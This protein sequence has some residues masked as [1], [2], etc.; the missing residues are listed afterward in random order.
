MD[1]ERKYLVSGQDG[2]RFRKAGIGGLVLTLVIAVLPNASKAFNDPCVIDAN[3]MT[4]S[5]NQEDGLGY[6]F[7]SPDTLNVQNLTAEVRPASGRAIDFKNTG[8]TLT[9]VHLNVDSSVS[10]L[11][12]TDG[13]M[14]LWVQ[15]WRYPATGD[16]ADGGDSGAVT[17][18]SYAEEINTSGLHSVG[19]LGLS[20]GSDGAINMSVNVSAGVGG[21]GG[22]GGAVAVSGSG[23]ID[24]DGLLSR[25]IF[26][27][28]AGGNG[29]KG[30][31][32]VTPGTG[33]RG[34]AGGSVTVDGSWVIDTNGDYADGI[35]ALSLGGVGGEGGGGVLSAPGGTGGASSNGGK[36]TVTLTGGRIITRQNVSSGVLAQSIGGFG[37][38]GAADGGLFYA[39]GGEGGAGGNGG[40][41]KIDS[42]ADITTYGI[43]SHALFAESI[44]GGG[45]AGGAAGSVITA[46]GGEGSVSGHGGR[47]DVI[48]SGRLETSGMHAIGI[49]AQ[50]IGG[51]GGDAGASGSIVGV[52][53]KSGAA[54]NGGVVDVEN[55]GLILTHGLLSHGVLAQSIGGGGGAAGDTGGIVAVGGGGAGGGDGGLVD[56]ENNARITTEGLLAKGLFVQSIGGGGGD[57]GSAGGFV[58]VGGSGSST[59]NGG[60]VIVS[61]TGTITTKLDL[62]EAILAQSIGGGGGSGGSTGGIFSFGGKGNSGGDAGTVTVTNSGN[63]ETNGSDSTGVFAQ[64]VGGGGGTGGGTVAVGSP[65]S[66]S[67]GGQG[68]A[69]GAGNNVTV[70]GIG[71]TISTSGDRSD[72]IFAQSVGGSGGN[73]G[74]AVSISAG[75][76]GSM[77]IAVGGNAGGGGAGGDVTVESSSVITTDGADATGIVAQSV[78][79]SGGNGGF[80]VAVAISQTGPSMSLA[81][82]GK[83]GEAGDSGGLVTMN[84]TGGSITTLGDRSGGILAQSVGGGGGNGGFSVSASGA[85]AAGALGF[86]GEGG[87]GRLGGTVDVT[88]VSNV[89]TSGTNANGITAQ[90][91][92][93]G[94]GNGGFSVVANVAGGSGSLSFGGT[95]G[96]GNLGGRVKLDNSGDIITG[97]GQAGHGD[98]SIGILAQSV[99]GG[100]G[101]GGYSIVGSASGSV[102]VNLSF[103][104]AGGFGG[105]GGLVDFDN[106]GSVTTTGNDAHGIVAQSVGGGGG[107]GG[108]SVKGSVSGSVDAGLAI[109][110]AGGIGANG[111]YV[112]VSNTG[113]FISTSGDRAFGLL[114]Q[115][116]GGQGGAGGYSVSAGASFYGTA[117][118]AIG[119][120]GGFGGQSSRVKVFNSANVSTTGSDAHGVLAQSVGGGGGAGGFGVAA[121][122]S[123]VNNLSVGIGGKGGLGGAVAGKVDV[124]QTGDITTT[125]ERAM[126]M[127]A[128]SVGGQGGDGGMSFAGGV[129]SVGLSVAVGGEG[130]HG[131]S[132]GN[133]QVGFDGAISTATNHSHGI[134]AQS[135]GGGGG[136]GGMAIKGSVSSLGDLGVA[137]GGL[138]GVGGTSG[139]VVVWAAGGS[140]STTGDFASGIIAQSAGGSGGDGGMSLTAGATSFINLNASIGGAGGAAGQAGNVVANVDASVETQGML[141]FGVVAQS[142]GGSG[143]TGGLSIAASVTAGPPIPGLGNS[144]NVSVGGAGG[145][146]AFGENVTVKTTSTVQTSGMLAH[147]I[148]AQSIGGS[149]GGGGMSVIGAVNVGGKISA[150]ANVSVG[151]WG[152]NGA[153]AGDVTVNSYGGLVKTTGNMANGILAQSIGGSGGSSGGNYSEA[154][155]GLLGGPDLGN[156]IGFNLDVGGKG[157]A[158]AIAG[159][160]VINNFASIETDGSFAHG[161]VGQSIGG[162]GGTGAISVGISAGGGVG[163]IGVDVGGTFP[164]GEAPAGGTAGTVTI[165]NSGASVTTQ[166][167]GSYGILAQSIGGA[168][169]NASADTIWF[170]YYP[171][172]PSNAISVDVSVGGVGGAGGIA[173]DVDVTNDASIETQGLVAHGIVAQSLGGG[174]GAGGGHINGAA[175]LGNIG[176]SI[177]GA[178]GLGAVAGTVDVTNGG[179]IFTK[180]ER[181]YGVLAQS[182]GG[183]GGEGGLVLSNGVA[184]GTIKLGI[185]GDGGVGGTSNVVTVVNTAG[186]KTEGVGSHGIM[187]Q[188]L[189]GGGGAGGHV[190]QGAVSGSGSL[191]VSV[192]GSGGGSAI[193]DLVSVT[194]SGGLIETGADNAHGVMAQS[195]GGTGGDGN[196]SVAGSMSLMPAINVSIGGSGGDS[197]VAGDVLVDVSNSI[198]TIGAGSHGIMAQSIGGGGGSAGFGAAGG[199]SGTGAI[200][201]GVGGSGGSGS[202]GALVSVS[203][204]DGTIHTTGNTSHGIMA[205]SIGGTGGTG[206]FGASGGLGL[207]SSFSASMGGSGGVGAIGGEANIGNG[208]IIVTEGNASYGLVAQSIGGGGGL[209]GYAFGVAAAA[210]PIFMT[211]STGGTGGTGAHGGYAS[212]ATEAAITTYGV[213][214]H[215]MFVQSIGGG[216][217]ATGFGDGSTPGSDVGYVLS[218]SIGGS[219]IVEGNGGTVSARN[220][221]VIITHGNAAHGVLAQSIGGGGGEGGSGDTE[222]GSD[223]WGDLSVIVGGTGGVVG[224]GGQVTANNYGDIWTHGTASMGLVAQSVGAGGGSGGAS[225]FGV[226]ALLELGGGDGASGDGGKV[227]VGLHGDILTDSDGG[228]G[229]LAQSIGGGGGFVGNLNTGLPLGPISLYIGYGEVGQIGLGK[230]FARDGGSLGSGGKVTVEGSGTIVTQGVG[231]HGILA[232]SIGGG[233]GLV[234]TDGTNEAGEILTLE[235]CLIEACEFLAGSVGGDGA[236]D[237]VTVT[238]SGGVYT[239]GAAAHG[240]FAQS[241][242]GATAGGT[243]DHSGDVTITLEGD[244]GE[245]GLQ[246]TGEGSAA[247]FAQ[248]LGADGS[249][250]IEITIG[251]GWTVVGGKGAGIGVLMRD[252]ATNTLANYGIITTARGLS[253][254]AV[255]G[256][257]GN[258]TI[259]NHFY[260]SGNI[261][262]GPGL[263]MFNN[264]SLAWFDA[265]AIVNLDGG[266]FLNSGTLAPGGIANVGVTT[267]S[268]YYIQSEFGHLQ[269]DWDFSQDAA[270]LLHV[271]GVASLAGQIDLGVIYNGYLVPGTDQVTVVSAIDGLSHAGLTL[272]VPSSAVASYDLVF[273]NSSE[274][275]ILHTV[276][277]APD[278]L[279]EGAGEMGD[280]LS[281]IQS[282]GSFAGFEEI[283]LAI[284]SLE[285]IEKLGK[286]YDQ[287]G[288]DIYGEVGLL[289][290]VNSNLL[291]ANLQSCKRRDGDYRFIRQKDCKWARVDISEANRPSSSSLPSLHDSSVSYGMGLQKQVSPGTH[292]GFGGSVARNSLKVSDTFR[293]EG[294]TAEL[295]LVVKKETGGFLVAGI[296][297]IGVAYSNI[298]RYLPL[299][300]DAIMAESKSKTTFQSATLSAGYMVGD[301]DFY[302]VPGFEVSASFYQSPE[303]SEQG[304]GAANLTIGAHDEAVYKIEPM[305][306]FGGEFEGRRGTL[307]RPYVKAG[308]AHYFGDTEAG[309]EVRFTG[310]PVGAGLLIEDTSYDDSQAS[311]TLGMD[312]LTVGGGVARLGYIGNFSD[313]V[314]RHGGFA[315]LSFPW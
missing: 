275:A 308:L 145:D 160:V 112:D 192:G 103:G 299:L 233:G 264:M 2:A 130:G 104:G 255:L 262:L 68:G 231:A 26:A 203:T 170:D 100:G 9:G 270:D 178:G 133:V 171:G 32:A 29:G 65:I 150:S 98:Q 153:Q 166:G 199:I 238:L 254:L 228:I 172:Q 314:E 161:I 38:A 248:S 213:S 273:P 267:V 80:A 94:G 59:G 92:G 288:G 122:V 173:G 201:V 200:S 11:T 300:G 229:V 208:S 147:A 61:N 239:S 185:G 118:V 3:S 165:T 281:D 180:G 279:P 295:G 159:L 20:E 169:G 95:G 181:S 93:G 312:V 243:L 75:V 87:E 27:A 56:V 315:K 227:I 302:L 73:G 251:E 69:G 176:A 184:G 111:G 128:Q 121:G 257:K 117:S 13:S 99:G 293:A 310:A 6:S 79:G 234:G 183:T 22:R 134:V 163:D 101:A 220:S 49:F 17:I 221:D 57:G 28:S 4:C 216:G 230:R 52:G 120:D 292:I 62:S 63:L 222:P 42:A 136:T 194:S 41:V 106:S 306:E 113:A 44:G 105:H 193:A 245:H 47:V 219:G 284:Y 191:N 202:A 54:S 126:G 50:S 18:V 108:F 164:V 137:V 174:G 97:G 249:G 258:E 149:G 240:V 259:D 298:D 246:S 271:E 263:N 286:A 88:N 207:Y 244:E 23:G 78:G 206:N 260:M 84:N 252:G 225:A 179:S 53:G 91:I 123:S 289:S 157:G 307:F 76:V 110:G 139:N 146:G 12:T 131:G 182:I 67:V 305:L 33:G 187:A 285:D 232:Q 142:I 209:G 237:V 55:N 35:A 81:I 115:S 132:A 297:T 212:A 274:I 214:S 127:V 109:G 114:V 188:S 72:G 102:G 301:K 46:I 43:A 14:G 235:Q 290:F 272:E 37:G 218:S 277:F 77:A 196:F 291:T 287:L 242:A 148:F 303:V 135:L 138:G 162:T 60:E 124:E 125:G 198:T 155:S 83:G 268:G 278:E 253:G 85:A 195:I 175:A 116:V 186:I 8:L 282:S 261:D 1:N 210:S 107:I 129:S 226:Q 269:I 96:L 86:G 215:A 190:I 250:D 31:T 70:N 154:F 21:D 66:I 309:I 211:Y 158:S 189:G 156:N 236:A 45:G 283:I 19:I 256:G 265:G 36:V 177:G 276:N 119:G 7:D 224:H 24:V 74:F 140:I 296:G 247:I 39:R 197:S 205:Q 64:S 266:M 30:V 15:N 71:G 34:G 90:S 311:L 141:S 48:N 58:A 143:G 10:I 51:G 241:I 204:H 168:G 144:A 223:P 217:G 280:A 40:D 82:G 16:G 5:G 25:G 313:N 152:G 151:G 304:A 89:T 294:E 167:Y